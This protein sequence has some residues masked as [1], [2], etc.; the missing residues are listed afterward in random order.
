MRKYPIVDGAAV[1]PEGITEIPERAFHIDKELKSVTIPDGVTK[2]GCAAFAHC[3]KLKTVIIPESVT[4]IDTYAFRECM[5]LKSITLPKG[6]KTIADR[7]FKDCHKLDEITIPEGVDAIGEAAFENCINLKH[8]TIPKGVKKI[9]GRAFMGCSHLESMLL[10]AGVSSIHVSCITRCMMLKKIYVPL[11]KKDYYIKRFEYK[12]AELFIEVE[13]GFVPVVKKE[14]PAKKAKDVNLDRLVM[15]SEHHAAAMKGRGQIDIPGEYQWTDGLCYRLQED[16]T[17]SVNCRDY[18]IK[19]AYIANFIVVD[20]IEYPVTTIAS[21]CF[22]E[23]MH[24]KE[25]TL[26]SNIRSVEQYAFW[27]C[28]NIQKMT[29]NGCRDIELGE[30][31]IS[32]KKAYYDSLET[33][34][35][36]GN[37]ARAPHVYINGDELTDLVVPEGTVRIRPMLAMHCIGLRTVRLPDSV[38]VIDSWAF[39]Y[40]KN[41]KSINL[42]QGLKAIGDYAFDKCKSLA[43][44]TVPPS[45]TYIGQQNNIL[46]KIS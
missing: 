12:P 7:L 46:K 29:F 30:D 25:V 2:I 23:C 8:V 36:I 40:C 4:E 18:A 14:K 44:L 17:A 19:K 28:D 42:P 16:K 26:P 11:G 27:D 43:P 32:I 1:F 45:V 10:P 38:E 6:L 9:K 3:P 20:G 34:L 22:Y 41:L 24:L 39:G 35:S 13:P 21:N 15:T 31:L 37:T 33:F 5:S